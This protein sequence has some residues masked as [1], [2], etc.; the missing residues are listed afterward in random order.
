M[1]TT[2][3]SAVLRI[4]HP[5]TGETL[6]SQ[7]SIVVSLIIGIP[8]L[9]TVLKA[10]HLDVTR[11]PRWAQWCPPF[12]LAGLPEMLVRLQAGTDLLSS[13]IDA[14]LAG[15]SAIGAYHAAKR[16][17]TSGKA[18]AAVVGLFLLGSISS[19]ACGLVRPEAPVAPPADAIC[20][21]IT[22]LD[23]VE[24]YLC[25]R[26]RASLEDKVEALQ[27]TREIRSVVMPPRGTE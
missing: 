2:L 16:I 18:T 3:G 5:I 6:M 15:L 4:D 19:T 12:V 9:L 13:G 26:T 25:A 20:A 17:V 24:T 21:K 1:P 8:F 7:D 23:A 11:L 10:V 27:E 14:V 22:W